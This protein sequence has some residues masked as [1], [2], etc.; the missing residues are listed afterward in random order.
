MH[1]AATLRARILACQACPQGEQRVQPV[2]A[3]DCL[4]AHWLVLGDAPDAAQARA[5]QPFVG[6]AGALLQAMLR[7]VAV[8]PDAPEAE[9]RAHL[10]LAIK[11]CPARPCSLDA[12]ALAACRAHLD[13]EIALVRPRV[14]LALGRWAIH[15][16]LADALAGQR[17]VLSALRGRPWAYRGVP[18]VVSYPPHYLL[19][20][21]QDKRA[22]WDDLKLAR[23]VV[24]APDWT[25]QVLAQPSSR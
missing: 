12:Q 5:G 8:Q 19:T 10:S 25:A 15:T 1:D 23:R 9:R 16:L 18:V 7:A 6:E 20:H 14:L 17:L 13:A 3:A 21:P 22:A 24:D 4:P 11:C 2:M